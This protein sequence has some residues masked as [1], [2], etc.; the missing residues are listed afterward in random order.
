MKKHRK[1][2]RSFAVSLAIGSALS[3]GTV[4]ASAMLLAVI[5]YFTK[6]PSALVGAFSLLALI[7]GGGISGFISTRMNGE[8]GKLTAILSGAI[9][10]VIALVAGL[11]Y[12]GGLLTASVLLNAA[13]F[14][15]ATALATIP[16]K[17]K[18]KH[19]RHRR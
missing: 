5:A 16:A 6:N 9:S 7:M 3:L 17:R 13:A 15:C 4:T 10:A 12:K 14:L 2:D 11:I 8:R 19:I 18:S 1:K